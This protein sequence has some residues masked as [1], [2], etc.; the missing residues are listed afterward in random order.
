MHDVVHVQ[1]SDGLGQLVEKPLRCELVK[2]PIFL[3]VVVQVSTFTELENDV[4]VAGRLDE[5]LKV[6]DVWMIEVR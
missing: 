6:N 4:K 5:L 3:Q 1:L 2:A